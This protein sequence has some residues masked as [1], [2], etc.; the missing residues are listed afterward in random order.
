MDLGCVELRFEIV[1]TSVEPLDS[2]PTGFDYHK[3]LFLFQDPILAVST[4]YS[5]LRIFNLIL[6]FPMVDMKRQ[7]QRLP[8][9]LSRLI[10][11]SPNLF[12]YVHL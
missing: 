1:C 8:L 9:L 11:C 7:S 4:P 10:F 3:K 12:I 5:K 2:L 6:I